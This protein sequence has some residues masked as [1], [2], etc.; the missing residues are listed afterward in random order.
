MSTP[1]REPWQILSPY[2]DQVLT[3]SEPDRSRWLEELQSKDAAL[4]SQLRELLERRQAAERDGFLERELSLPLLGPGLAGQA[5]GPYRLVRPIGQGGMGTVWLAERCDGRF[6]RQAAV[7]FLSVAL[8]GHGGE[9]R[10][11]REGAILG[12]LSHPNIADLLDAGVTANAQPY[13]V[14]EYVE[15]DPIDRYCDQQKLGIQERVGL[16]LDVLGAVSHAHANLIVHR[17]IKPSNVLVNRSG[18]VKLLDFGIAKLLEGEGQEGAATLLT[19]EAGSALTP[20]YAAPE[21]L[22]GGAV[23]TATDVYGLGVLL[24]VL[25]TGQHPAGPGPHSPANLLKATVETEPLRPSEAVSRNRIEDRAASRGTVPEKLFRQLR[26]DVDTIV[27]KALKK[28]PGERYTSVAGL[29][30]DLHRFLKHEP[31]KARPDTLTYRASKFIRR[32]R[33]SVT[34][35]I[36]ALSAIISGAAV[37]IYEARVAQRRFQDVR[38]LAHVFVFDLYDQIAKLEG[39]TKVR[40]SMVSTG[41]QYLDSLA[42]NAG[43]DLELQKEIAAAY[44][45]IGDAQGFP[46]HPNLGRIED[47]IASYQ[48]AGEIYRRISDKDPTYL[49]DLAE[50]YLEDAAL[51]RF[52]HKLNDAR[53]LALA[54]IQTIDH[55]R[56]L[57]P[58]DPALELTYARAWCAVAGMDEDLQHFREAWQHAS[59]CAELARIQVAKER[60]SETLTVLAAADEH[61]GTSAL[62]AGMLTVALQAFNEDESLLRELLHHEP[63]NPQ[64]HRRLAVLHLYRSS[65]YYDDM[66]PTL[67]DPSRALKDVQSYLAAAEEMVRNDPENTQA[68]FSHAVA[69]FRVSFC[70]RE[71]DAKAAIAMANASLHIFDQMA[72]SGQPSYLVTSRRVRALQRL[73][74]AQLKAGRV[75]E[76][77]DSAHSALDAQRAIITRYPSQAEEESELVLKLILAGETSAATGSLP[78]AE[79]LLLEA[80]KIAEHRAEDRQLTNVVVLASV[81]RALFAFYAR[82]HRGAEARASSQRLADL[83][84]SFP[85]SS[86]YVDLQQAATQRLL[87]A[88]R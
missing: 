47:A 54:S 3:L 13:L 23:T 56:I 72:A 67:N 76:A 16:F 87:T 9:D 53:I 41:L 2:L 39:S 7:K 69:L 42:R 75:R 64:L 77:R 33:F 5:I 21:Q 73:G 24:Y 60:N 66:G 57:H 34:A 30:D 29:Y 68:R 18:Q 55:V 4:A 27:A 78:Q 14:L 52:T 58:I 59:R 46:T 44:M 10:F 31:I 88:S 22:T 51:I 43:S 19:R 82:N 62:S 17:D 86:E 35:A 50:Y 45:K 84:Q 61:L 6:E 32:N 63:N 37:S 28:K 49:P 71:S 15:G 80:R 85:E 8:V 1:S 83:W 65:L 48:K 81:E 74:E 20:E 25:L 79:T 40:E 12:R 36:L 70:L 38:K 26:G 11:R